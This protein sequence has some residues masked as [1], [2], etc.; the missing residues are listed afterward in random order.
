MVSSSS[1]QPASASSSQQCYHPRTIAIHLHTVD[2]SAPTYRHA[3]A[4]LP[5]IHTIADA[6]VA[7]RHPGSPML[8]FWQM[9]CR[10]REPCSQPDPTALLTNLISPNPTRQAVGVLRDAL[11]ALRPF[12]QATHPRVNLFHA[13]WVTVMFPLTDGKTGQMKVMP[14]FAGSMQQLPA[15]MCGLNVTWSARMCERR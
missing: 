11:A 9:A 15:R 2:S 7:L 10:M 3:A 1:A 12:R 8:V 4:R 6:T 14:A 5:N 13:P